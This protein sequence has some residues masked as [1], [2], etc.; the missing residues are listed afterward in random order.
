MS[1]PERSDEIRARQRSRARVTALILVAFAIL[2]FFV[3]IAKIRGL[4]P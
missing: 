1:D 2:F 4:N 3:T